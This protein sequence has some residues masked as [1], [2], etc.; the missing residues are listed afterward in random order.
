MKILLANTNPIERKRIAGALG[1]AGY[2]VTEAASGGIANKLV[3][4][5]LFDGALVEWHLAGG[6]V[7][8]LRSRGRP[9]IVMTSAAWTPQ[10]IATAY[11]HGADDLLKTPASREETVGRADGLRRMRARLNETHARNHDFTAAFDLMQSRT[12][13]DMEAIVARELGEL[14]G[15][16]LAA[17]A[18]EASYAVARASELPLILSTDHIEVRL[19]VG[20]D[21]AACDAIS[22]LMLGGDT[23]G[24]ALGDALREFANTAGGALKR[25]AMG[26]GVTFTLGLPCDGHLPTGA[27]TNTHRWLARTESGFCLAFAATIASMA[28]KAVPA[29]ALCEGMVIAR[30]VTNPAGLLLASAGTYLTRSA[31]ERLAN[32]AG[33]QTLI[34]VTE[35]APGRAAPAAA[36]S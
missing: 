2:Q 27:T 22:Q 7:L 30:D 28:P 29:G 12:W 31:A 15:L 34:E 1:A 8:R 16:A 5:Q 26:E 23:R 17:A 11:A 36:P 13:R 21:A 18:F 32:L 9:Y 4:E 10:D 24:E 19:T 3:E 33:Q 25:T 35:L 6:L 14:L 20:A